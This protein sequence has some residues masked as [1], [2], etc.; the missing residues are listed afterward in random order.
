MFARLT[1]I[2]DPN[3]NDIKIITVGLP[4]ISEVFKEI[5]DTIKVSEAVHMTQEQFTYHLAQRSTSKI[6]HD[7]SMKFDAKALGAPKVTALKRAHWADRPLS[8]E[9]DS[10]KDKL[11]IYHFAPP[12]IGSYEYEQRVANGCK[13]FRQEIVGKNKSRI[14]AKA[15]DLDHTGKWT[16]IQT[17][18]APSPIFQQLRPSSQNTPL[19]P[20]SGKWSTHFTASGSTPAVASGSRTIFLPQVYSYCHRSPVP[21]RRGAL[22]KNR[23]LPRIPSGCQRR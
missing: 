17:S 3:D 9:R 13:I 18:T 8:I 7:A 22:R 2:V 14:I 10:I 5:L 21:T 12:R 6:F 4:A 11:G 16:P 15:H 20:S 1:T 23:K 19:S